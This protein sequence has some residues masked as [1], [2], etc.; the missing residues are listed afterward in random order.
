MEIELLRNALRFDR[1]HIP[2][3]T[4]GEWTRVM[5]AADQERLTLALGVRFRVGPTSSSAPDPLVRPSV[6]PESVAARIDRNLAANEVRFA[7]SRGM[8]EEIAAAF[9]IAGV[10]TAVLK[11]FSHTGKYA[12]CA[13]D[14]PQGDLDL[15]CRREQILLACDALKRLG[16]APISGTE[17]VPTDHAPP[18]IRKTA[19]TWRGDYFDPQAPIAVE[20]HYQFWDEHT[21]RIRLD[22]L[23]AF[24]NRRQDESIGD[25][26]F[27]AL[28]PVDRIGYAAM[29][30]VRHLLRG[31]FRLFHAYELA[32]FLETTHADQEFWQ[33]WQDLHAGSL[34]SLETIAF[35]FASDWFG[36]R[37]PPQV[38]SEWDQ[39]PDA[40]RR[41]FDDF[42][43]A[44]LA[45]KRRPNKNELWLHLSLLESPQD[46]R[47][48]AVRRLLPL[49]RQKTQYAAHVPPELV[50]W[51]LRVQRKMFQTRFA[52][53]RL[54][55]HARS[56]LPTLASGA[57]FWFKA[58]GVNS[59]LFAFLIAA[60]LFN[61][62]MGIYF[63]LHNLFLLDRGFR[64]DSLGA[65]SSALGVGSLTGTMPAAFGLHRY[66]VRRLL[67]LAFA[68]VPLVS[69]LRIVW[70]TP[71]VL[72]GSGFAAGFL[73]SLYAVSLAPTIAQWTTESARPFAFSLVFSLGI[74]TGI[75]SSLIG[76][77][78]PAILSL[79]DA[80]LLAC[81]IAA[82]GS[83]VA[84][85][86][87]FD[88]PA[89]KEDRIYPRSR[90]VRRFLTA[91][92]LWSLATGA[93]N[94][95]FNAY[96]SRALHFRVSQ[97]GSVA[98]AG[99]VV[100]VAAILCAPL[101]LSR[102]GIVAG[103]MSMQLAAAIALALLSIG[104]PGWISGGLYALYMGFQ[105]MSEP[106]MYS[107]LMDEVAPHERGG[108]AALNF[109]V[110][111]GTQAIAAMAS[112]LLIKTVGYMPV[113]MFAAL[114]AALAAVAFRGLLKSAPESPGPI[115]CDVGQ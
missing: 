19:W 32:H 69:A 6:L 37:V 109:F 76:G 59:Q 65:V 86:L 15:F 45:A 31:D 94:P 110:I 49:R 26:Y 23:D 87:K 54:S 77:H 36:C 4:S 90:F 96:F 68:G 5:R 35:R 57:R 33:S 3:L 112:G 38:A 104:S 27:P 102:F 81:L 16:Y 88:K 43:G 42:S 7:R 82:L 73:M 71:E 22:G 48:V 17:G 79:R 50:T 98:A 70:N 24:W 108:A 74:G 55:H 39:F 100:Q 97:I 28:A 105:Y 51:R 106:G 80:L 113:L 83:L 111:S 29:H 85:R 93:F 13:L 11:G 75:L 14:R 52:M 47:A 114:L 84:W 41:W 20:L 91:I 56:T 67:I 8:Y 103:V 21:E 34:R 101:L 10:E 62:G 107:L 2:D 9:Q 25:F 92:F 40:A 99:Q 66:G 30:L 89:Q 60:S 1:P 46:R 44:P 78:L 64:E 12:T 61:L 63:L 18:M 58:K 95:F 115:A 53:K 72:I